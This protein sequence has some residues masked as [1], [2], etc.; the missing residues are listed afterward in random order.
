M[1]GKSDAYLFA[2]GA[3]RLLR[4]AGYRVK[5]SYEGGGWFRWKNLGRADA[6][7]SYRRDRVETML[8][9]HLAAARKENEGK[10]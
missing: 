10:T 8:G 3:T 9:N 2:A 1:M 6:G 4:D 5:I 7:F